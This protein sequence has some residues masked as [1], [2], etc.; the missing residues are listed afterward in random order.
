M[1]VTLGGAVAQE[2]SQDAAVA[3]TGIE[4]LATFER[5]H[6]GLPQQLEES[7]FAG[8]IEEEVGWLPVGVTRV[9]TELRPAGVGLPYALCFCRCFVN[10]ACV[11]AG[12]RDGLALDGPA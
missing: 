2:V 1:Q 3:T 6:V 9:E 11:L 12:R 7:A 10:H 4:H 5:Q 8:L